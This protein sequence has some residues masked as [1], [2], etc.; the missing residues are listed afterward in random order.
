[1]DP[2]FWRERWRAG[3]TGFHR[4]HFHPLLVKYADRIPSDARV[5]VPLAGKSLDLRFLAE[6]GNDV[7][8]V[9]LVEEAVRGFFA[10]AG[11]TPEVGRVNGHPVYR[12][13]RVELH[14]ADFFDVTPVQLGPL[15]AVY[16]RASLIAL[17]PDLRARYAAHLASLAPPESGI[18]MVTIDYDQSE[19]AGPPFS[20]PPSE[21]EAIFGGPF[22]VFPLESADGLAELP[23]LAS[24]G[25]TRLTEHALWL[26]RRG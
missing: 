26:R 24:R 13:C 21:V 7:V 22:E 12:A 17:P 1:M 20:V 3:Q 9:E 14:V 8:G 15:T 23:H 11:W 18:L 10:D 19:M 4:S 2:E 25:L 5:L 16:D 6:R